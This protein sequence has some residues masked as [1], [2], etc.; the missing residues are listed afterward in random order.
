MIDTYTATKEAADLLYGGL[1]LDAT[2]IVPPMAHQ[3]IPGEECTSPEGIR[4]FVDRVTSFDCGIVVAGQ[5]IGKHRSK[6]EGIGH[7][8]IYRFVPYPS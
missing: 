5:T 2:R 4:M 3:P 6:P 1:P 7:C 8:F